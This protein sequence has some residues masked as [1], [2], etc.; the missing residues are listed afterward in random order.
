M[1]E[2]PNA[3]TPPA[4]HIELSVTIFSSIVNITQAR[5]SLSIRGTIAPGLGP[6]LILL[7]LTRRIFVAYFLASSSRLGRKRPLAVA[8]DE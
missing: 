8:I 3:H 7:V 4:N 1:I 6:G 5:I 2:R